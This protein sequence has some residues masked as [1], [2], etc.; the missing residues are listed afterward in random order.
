MKIK[1]I[2]LGNSTDIISIKNSVAIVYY[3]YLMIIAALQIG[4]SY[5]KVEQVVIWKFA[6]IVMIVAFISLL[7]HFKFPKKTFLLNTIAVFFILIALKLS[8]LY[9]SGFSP[10]Q[11]LMITAFCITVVYFYDYRRSFIIPLLFI[12]I[13][14]IE[15]TYYQDFKYSGFTDRIDSDLERIIYTAVSLNFYIF[16]LSSFF[17]SKLNHLIQKYNEKKKLIDIAKKGEKDHLSKLN[18]QF[19]GIKEAVT[20]NSH[21]LR[22]PISRIQGLLSLH[23][24]NLDSDD[25][26]TEENKLDFQK[27]LKESLSELRLELE[28]FEQIIRT[29]QNDNSGTYNAILKVTEG[30]DITIDINSE[31]EDDNIFS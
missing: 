3:L 23:Q 6:P 1:N 12:I 13:H 22:A 25:D 8:V 19:N 15:L 21:K 11:Y 27:M 7:A 20:T 9:K 24:A 29:V 2:L 10:I 31:K 28:N 30:G 5:G 14:I 16:L 18:E 26:N 4:F 17:S